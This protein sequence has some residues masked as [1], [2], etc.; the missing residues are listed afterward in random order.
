MIGSKIAFTSIVGITVVKSTIEI[1]PIFT[2][3]VY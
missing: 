1:M 2:F 3:K